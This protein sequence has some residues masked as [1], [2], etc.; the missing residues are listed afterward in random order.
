MPIVATTLVIVLLNCGIRLLDERDAGRRQMVGECGDAP[1]GHTT[2]AQCPS[3]GAHGV[4]MRIW[5]AINVWHA[6]A[7]W[8]KVSATAVDGPDCP[9]GSKQRV[10][11]NTMTG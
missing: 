10:A 1:G 6:E 8:Q 4:A 3:L 7:T 9:G 11:E 5:E 2:R